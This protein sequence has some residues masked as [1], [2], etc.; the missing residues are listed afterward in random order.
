MHSF[1]DEYVLCPAF[2]LLQPGLAYCTP[3]LFLYNIWNFV[4]TCRYSVKYAQTEAPPTTNPLFALVLELCLWA[5]FVIVTTLFLT[6]GK[7]Q[8]GETGMEIFLSMK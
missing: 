5:S 3:V 7:L 1:E 8:I 6:T 2:I 4:Q